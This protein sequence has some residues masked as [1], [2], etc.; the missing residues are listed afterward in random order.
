MTLELFAKYASDELHLP[1]MVEEKKQS[2]RVIATLPLGIYSKLEEVATKEGRAVGNLAGF[3]LEEWVRSEIDKEF[4]C[5]REIY[6][7]LTDH[8]NN[9]EK[10]EKQESQETDKEKKHSI[11]MRLFRDID[12][13][14]ISALYHPTDRDVMYEL[15]KPYSVAGGLQLNEFMATLIE[16]AEYA[17]AVIPQIFE[18]I[19]PVPDADA[20]YDPSEGRINALDQYI[21]RIDRL[22]GSPGFDLKWISRCKLAV[23]ESI[24]YVPEGEW[25]KYQG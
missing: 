9:A 1:K 12:K 6:K 20:I 19:G 23:R 21:S 15:E 13:R 10:S 4:Y 11:L 14:F 3:I 25:L 24:R 17:P 8:L 18:R 16:A 2:G 5:P 22:E 7:L